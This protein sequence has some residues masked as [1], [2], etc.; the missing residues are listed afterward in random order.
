MP[1]IARGDGIPDDDIKHC[2][3]GQHNRYR[4][5][6]DTTIFQ[7]IDVGSTDFNPLETRYFYAVVPVDAIG[8]MG[9]PRH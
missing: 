2:R 8:I 4:T 1:R 3:T 7:D 9:T 5:F 6:E